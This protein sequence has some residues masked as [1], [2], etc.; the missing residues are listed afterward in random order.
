MYDFKRAEEF[1]WFGLVSAGIALLEIAVNWDPN[2][3]TDW[4]TWAI[5]GA[6]GLVRAFA[7]GVLAA[8]APKA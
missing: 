1:V 7:G 4:N 6:G 3:I 5:A 8:L 2:V